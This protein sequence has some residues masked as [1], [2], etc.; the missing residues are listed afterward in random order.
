MTICFAVVTEYKSKKKNSH[1][2][3]H[4]FFLQGKRLIVSSDSFALVFI[5]LTWFQ[6]AAVGNYNCYG[7]L[8][9]AQNP[10]KEGG[11]SFFSF[12]L[13]SFLL[14]IYYMCNPSFPQEP[15][16]MCITLSLSLPNFS[17]N[18]CGRDLRLR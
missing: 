4:P 2:A 7:F 16:D 14:L 8:K 3:P 10:V 17:H 6:R 12:F 9:N 5:P 18:G 1:I 13:F 11:S 15:K